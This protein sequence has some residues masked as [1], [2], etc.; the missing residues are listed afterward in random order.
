MNVLNSQ[1]LHDALN[2]IECHLIGE[3]LPNPYTQEIS[4]F[5]MLYLCFPNYLT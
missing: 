5:A 4:V 3:E 1:P 2:Q